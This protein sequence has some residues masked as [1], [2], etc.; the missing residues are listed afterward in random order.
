[1]YAMDESSSIEVFSYRK[2]KV[3][4]NCVWMG[5]RLNGPYFLVSSLTPIQKALIYLR[6]FFK[7]L[8]YWLELR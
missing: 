7:F 6:S 5:Q 1:M 4:V 8:Y 2:L 3:K